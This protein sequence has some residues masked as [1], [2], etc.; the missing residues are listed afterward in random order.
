MRLLMA[1]LLYRPHIDHG[2]KI[3]T[4]DFLLREIT[5]VLPNA[6]PEDLPVDLASTAIELAAHG[7]AALVAPA[8]F[9]FLG[10][11]DPFAAPAFA[12]L[13]EQ[14]NRQDPAMAWRH[15]RISIARRAISTR[16]QPQIG[17]QFGDSEPMLVRSDSLSGVGRHRGA[18]HPCG[19]P[20]QVPFQVCLN[21]AISAAVTVEHR[22]TVTSLGRGARK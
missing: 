13:D 11:H 5:L 8:L 18:V 4:T 9:V 14:L 17:C 1:H 15:A 12:L 6:A 10:D 3:V 16:G 20:R 21:L 2:E 22:L 7:E 19:T